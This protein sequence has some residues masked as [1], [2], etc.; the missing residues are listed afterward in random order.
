MHSQREPFVERDET[1]SHRSSAP[2]LR[3]VDLHHLIHDA[4]H[5]AS[6]AKW[7]GTRLDIPDDA[8]AEKLRQVCDAAHQRGLRIELSSVVTH[9]IKEYYR[10]VRRA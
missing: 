8:T 1:E 9:C 5:S 4:L 6:R 10:P 3:G 7:S 2:S